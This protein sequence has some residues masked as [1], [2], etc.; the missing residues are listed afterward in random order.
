MSPPLY[1]HRVTATREAPS[2]VTIHTSAGPLNL[3][4]PPDAEYVTVKHPLALREAASLETT[5]GISCKLILPDF[6]QTKA[7]LKRTAADAGVEVSGDNPTKDDY[8]RALVLAGWQPMEETESEAPP[9]DGEPIED[10]N[11]E[12]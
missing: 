7:E 12:E 8:T 5:R 6:G 2:T 4:R 10:T 1:D 9:A 3:H 11:G